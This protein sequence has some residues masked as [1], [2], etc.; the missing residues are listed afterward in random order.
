MIQR[1]LVF[2]PFLSHADAAQRRAGSPS[3][4][5][6][7]DA[8]DRHP[9][10]ARRRGDAATPSDLACVAQR[11]RRRTRL[12]KRPF[13]GLL[14]FPRLP[15]RRL[16]LPRCRRQRGRRL[17]RKRRRVGFL[18]ESDERD[19]K[20]LGRHAGRRLPPD[21]GGC[22]WTSIGGF[23]VASLQT[24]AFPVFDRNFASMDTLLAFFV[25]RS[26]RF[27]LPSAAAARFSRAYVGAGAWKWPPLSI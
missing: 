25:R 16:Q 1:W 14:H 20:L 18:A 7:Q 15:R 27:L 26:G 3:P 19:A 9:L 6:R 23:V 4:H 5:A 21:A 12:P 17:S 22:S 11:V 10:R 8:R 2:L 24:R 13:R